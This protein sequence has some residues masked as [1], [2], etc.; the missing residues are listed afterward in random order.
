MKQVG[1]TTKEKI[2]DI[3]LDLFAV[4]GYM[5]VSI[6]D[7]SGAVGIKESSIYAHFKNKEEILQILLQRA[8]ELAAAKKDSFNQTLANVFSITC[9]AFITVGVSYVEGYLTEEKIYKF[10]QILTLEKQRNEK[11]AELYN[12]ILFSEPLEHHKTVFSYLTA[13]GYIKE[14]DPEHLAAEYQ[15]LILFI[16]LK[17]FAIPAALNSETKII[18]SNELSVLL[19]Q[20]YQ[21]YFVKEPVNRES[22]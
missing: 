10:I 9:E 5:T 14:N 1:Y 11:A 15:A 21:H 19:T 2:L 3:A 17:Y 6:R 20:F 12:K 8:E 4:H 16:F 7:I 22:I 18:A 13:E